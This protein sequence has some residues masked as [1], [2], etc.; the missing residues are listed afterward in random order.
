MYYCA[1]SYGILKYNKNCIWNAKVLIGKYNIVDVRGLV[2]V[3]V[4]REYVKS[5]QDCP[6]LFC[7]LNL[8]N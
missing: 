3:F 6:K 4:V 1:S 2:E 5:Y 8:F 7:P